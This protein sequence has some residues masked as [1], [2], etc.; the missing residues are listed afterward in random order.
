MRP[1]SFI[2]KKL[3]EVAERDFGIDITEYENCISRM[4]ETYYLYIDSCN[5]KCPL[6]MNPKTNGIVRFDIK[7]WVDLLDYNEWFYCKLLLRPLSD[8]TKEEALEVART[9]H[10]EENIEGWQ[11]V[12]YYSEKQMYEPD[13]M[14][15]LLSM[16][17]DL[18]GLINANLAKDK[19][20]L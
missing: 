19:T 4:K 20:K 10:T 3:A 5:V 11:V 8:I 1:L 16:G 18:F 7:F 9:T 17:F 2:E 13:E 6:S 12:D 15:C 14:R